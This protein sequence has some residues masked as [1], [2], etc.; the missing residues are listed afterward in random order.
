MDQMTLRRRRGASTHTA[1]RTSK[2][3]RGRCVC[4]RGLHTPASFAI[5]R[6]LGPASAPAAH[7]RDVGDVSSVRA[8]LQPGWLEIRR[9]RDRGCWIGGCV[10]EAAGSEQFALDV[11]ITTH[12]CVRLSM[13]VMD[14]YVWTS[15]YYVVDVYLCLEGSSLQ[16]L[17]CTALLQE[18]SSLQC[19]RCA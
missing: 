2:S 16:C 18:G 1:G 14:V 12:E 15:M 6:P 13:Y 19:M 4:G 9:L 3:E 17:R 5:C 7:H 8:S 11:Q 10:T